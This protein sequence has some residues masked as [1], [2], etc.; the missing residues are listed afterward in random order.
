MLCIL[1]VIAVGTLLGIV[2]LLVERALPAT[3]A[4]RW[5]WCAI[6]P[7]SMVI[8][9]VY[10]WRHNWAVTEISAQQ[11]NQLSLSH[12]LEMA[13]LT[14]LDRAWWARTESYDQAINQVWII[15]SGILVIWGLTNAMRVSHIVRSSRDGAGD[16]R[17]SGMIDGVPGVVTVTAGPATVGLLRSEV[18]VPRW[19]LALPGTQRQ[20][21]L[22]HEEE[23]RRAHDARLLFVAS[24]PL[25]LMPWNL[26]MWWQLRRLC[27]AV[28]MDCDNRVVAAL[29]DRNAYGELLLKVA[30]AGS[31]G[32]RLQPAFLGMGMLERRLNALLAP[33]P[34]RHVQRLLLPAAALSILLLVLWMPHP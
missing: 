31:R 18:L 17:Q 7:I 6:I 15:V 27:L 8:P 33:T 22:R 29:G 24:L 13:S 28:E 21:V 3:A 10:R 32:P 4:R 26:A 1:Y 14:P 11:S 12:S 16:S 20:Y 5:L 25:L 9:G 23:H 19:V 2:G 30:Q 34:L